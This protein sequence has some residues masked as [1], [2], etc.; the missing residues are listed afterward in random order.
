MTHESALSEELQ[1]ARLRLGRALDELATLVREASDSVPSD[2]RIN[3]REL[4][5]KLAA[6]EEFVKQ[7]DGLRHAYGLA[8]VN[9]RRI[10]RG[11]PPK[12]EAWHR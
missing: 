4:R 8:R 2:S 11:L 7:R 1:T 12:V 9:A 5:Y 6:V 10:D 3:V